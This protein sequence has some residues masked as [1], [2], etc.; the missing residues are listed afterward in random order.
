VEVAANFAVPFLSKGRYTHLA[1]ISTSGCCEY[2]SSPEGNILVIFQAWKGRVS[3][4][5]ERKG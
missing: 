5:E 2:H 1:E 3:N 4:W